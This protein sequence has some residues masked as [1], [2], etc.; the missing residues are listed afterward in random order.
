M[1]TILKI[2]LTFLE[3]NRILFKLDSFE[4][5][6]KCEPFITELCAFKSNYCLRA[7]PWRQ[8]ILLFNIQKNKMHWPHCLPAWVT[9][10]LCIHHFLWTHL[11]KTSGTRPILLTWETYFL[12]KNKLEQSYDYTSTSVQR[13]IKIKYKYLLSS[14]EKRMLLYSKKIHKYLSF[15]F[16]M[17]LY[18]WVL[19]GKWSEA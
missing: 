16:I 3:N 7:K 15:H 11:W 10:S 2:K 14:F 17:S 1:S 19:L 12:A 5:R 6:I 4:P 8:L 9:H 18:L 13:N